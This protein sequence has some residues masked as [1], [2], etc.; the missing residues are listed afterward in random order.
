MFRNAYFHP[1]KNVICFPAAILQAPFFSKDFDPA[2]CFGGICAVIG[3]EMV[4]SFDD[5]GRRFDHNGNVQDWW[6]EDDAERFGERAKVIIDQFDQFEV[7]GLKV[8]GS[9]TQG[10]NIA[11]LGGMKVAFNA[12]Q[13]WFKKRGRQPDLDGFTPEQR[14][15]ISWARG[16]RNNITEDRAKTLVTID[17]HAPGKYRVLGPMCNLEEWYKAFDVKEGDKMFVPVEKRVDIW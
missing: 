10:E 2:L 6:T 17:P 16:W 3:H 7:H 11:D 1:N 5:S 13:N 12:M 15:F 9:L 14:F 8:Q 4:H